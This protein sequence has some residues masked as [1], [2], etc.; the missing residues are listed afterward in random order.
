MKKIAFGVVALLLGIVLAFTVAEIGLRLLKPQRTG[1]TQLAYDPRVGSIPVPNHHGR[2]TLPG[3][4]QY[5]FTHD[6][7][8]RRNTGAVDTGK[9][10]FRVLLLGDSFT[11]G[12]GVND[13][14][15]F[16]YQLGE[17]LSRDGAAVAVINAGNPG[18][19]TDYASR[20]FE[21]VGNTLHP[22]VTV[23]CFFPNDFRDNSRSRI[24]RVAEDGTVSVNPG[25][26]AAY[27]KKEFFTRT[28]VY[29]WVISW[30]HLA[31]AF[32]SAAIRMLRAGAR[33][34]EEGEG[35]VVFYPDAKDG[36]SNEQNLRATRIFL[37]RLATAVRGAGSDFAVFYLPSADNVKWYRETGEPSKDERA[38]RALL[39]SERA[40][41]VSLTPALA[42][43]DATLEALYYDET[44]LGR[45][46][47]HW[48]PL[49]HS[50]AAE[51][52]RQVLGERLAKRK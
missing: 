25:L 36:W 46:G 32:K 6:S 4:Y 29:S 51:Q 19:G 37:D 17:R 28:P 7:N 31:N 52:M 41:M 2:I 30:S 13:N 8:G 50:I 34:G 48:T 26:G 33:A 49:G 5:S 16:A 39:S 43:S 47:G 15:T 24:Y 10:R 18:K 14:E 20:F 27:A 35:A 40:L 22:D 23:L 11:Y 9:A 38:L 45:P 42:A 21:T 44:Q 12:V 3:V 1:P